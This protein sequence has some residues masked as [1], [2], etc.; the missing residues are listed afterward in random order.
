MLGQAEKA[1]QAKPGRQSKSP[2]A[3]VEQTQNQLIK[4][5]QPWR[6]VLL[7]PLNARRLSAAATAGLH[8]PPISRTQAEALAHSGPR[9]VTHV[10]RAVLL[11]IEKW[12]VDYPLFEDE[13]A[14]CVGLHNGGQDCQ[15]WTCFGFELM[16]LGWAIL[17]WAG[18]FPAVFNRQPLQVGLSRRFVNE[19]GT[20]PKGSG[21]VPK[22]L[23]FVDMFCSDL[24]KSFP[25]DEFTT[26]SR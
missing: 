9:L 17:T 20:F 1:F 23:Q 26:S 8:Q 11:K 21:K 3:K 16:T 10:E 24:L 4:R 13:F 15:K 6:D 22:S 14:V 18:R 2:E 12:V 19:L 7:L 5:L 25:W